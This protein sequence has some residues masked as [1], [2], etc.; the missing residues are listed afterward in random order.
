MQKA[1]VDP[2]KDSEMDL[3]EAMLRSQR[4][5]AFF[6]GDFGGIFFGDKHS[7]LDGFHMISW[8]LGRFLKSFCWRLVKVWTFFWFRADLK[9]SKHLGTF[10]SPF[11]LYLWVDDTTDQWFLLRLSTFYLWILVKAGFESQKY[12]DYEVLPTIMIIHRMNLRISEICDKSATNLRLS[13]ISA[14]FV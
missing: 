5:L 1:T 2:F 10:T 8:Y 9:W 13:R 4:R 12:E 3:E 11:S 7:V 6:R 14:D